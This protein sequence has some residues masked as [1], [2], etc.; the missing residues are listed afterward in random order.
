MYIDIND[1]NDQYSGKHYET[2]IPFAYDN[3]V[4]LYVSYNGH[5]HSELSLQ[6]PG[7]I[8]KCPICGDNTFLLYY[9][10]V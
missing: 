2:D 4:L 7:R 1:I 5:N 8:K 9:V 6:L 10:F 3:T